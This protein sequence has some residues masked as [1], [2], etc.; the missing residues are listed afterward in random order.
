M[1]AETVQALKAHIAMN[2]KDVQRSV[3]FYRKLFGIEP[4]KV[5]EGY[6][7]FDVSNPPLNFAL[8]EVPF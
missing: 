7:K 8:N 6:A 3:N 4:S 5:R 2:V 1:A